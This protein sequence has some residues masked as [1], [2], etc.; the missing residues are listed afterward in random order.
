MYIKELAFRY[1]I[2]NKIDFIYKVANLRNLRF[3]AL[4]RGWRGNGAVEV[5]FKLYL[6]PE[7]R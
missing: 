6:H 3:T 1:W 2:K 4:K 5:I 7:S